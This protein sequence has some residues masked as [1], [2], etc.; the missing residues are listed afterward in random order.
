[1]RLARHLTMCRPAAYPTALFSVRQCGRMAPMVRIIVTLIGRSK[2]RPSKAVPYAGS[3]ARGH[4]QRMNK[5]WLCTAHR[6]RLYSDSLRAR[7]VAWISI[8]QSSVTYCSI[9]S[10]TH[11]GFVALK[12]SRT[13]TT[14]EPRPAIQI[15][16]TQKSYGGSSRNR[17]EG[18]F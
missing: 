14:H 16:K 3:D 2:S 8:M 1:M 17:G 6:C 15:L 9:K 12:K 10:F 13:G 11:P 4:A 5:I 7:W 18:D